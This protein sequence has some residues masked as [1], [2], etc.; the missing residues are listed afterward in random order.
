M[1]SRKIIKLAIEHPKRT[2]TDV[3]IT[4]DMALMPAV[5]EITK[6][7]RKHNQITLHAA[8]AANYKALKIA[9]IIQ[10]SQKGLV[11]PTVST[12]TIS[13]T[14]YL[15]PTKSGEVQTAKKRNMNA[16]TIVL[17]IK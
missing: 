14:D 15:M 11:I 12:S 4:K 13:T 9:T 17:S 1:D 8:G 10:S 2:E 5:E 16:V 3:Y 6:K 7:L